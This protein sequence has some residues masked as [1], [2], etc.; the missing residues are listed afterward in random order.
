MGHALSH[1][2]IKSDLLSTDFCMSQS[3]KIVYIYIIDMF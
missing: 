3:L 1:L 2:H